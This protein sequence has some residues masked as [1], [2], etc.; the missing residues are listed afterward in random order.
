[1][2]ASFELVVTAVRERERLQREV[3]HLAAH[4]SLTKLPNRAEAERLLTSALQ[5]ARAEHSRVALLFLD[6]DHFKACNDTYGHHAGDHVLRVAA[7]R[8]TGQIRS[9]DAACRLGGDEF[10][11]I[12]RDVGPDHQVAATGERIVA[13]LGAPVYYGEHVLQVGASVGITVWPSTATANADAEADAN[14]PTDAE[15]AEQMLTKADAAVYRA[16]AAGRN[17]AVF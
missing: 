13:A 11:V 9:H 4:D 3:S 12:L 10:V 14:E 15:V 1:M 17:V 7:E 6:L 2:H 8:I 16:K 5:A